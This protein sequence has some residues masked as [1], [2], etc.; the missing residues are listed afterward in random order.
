[1]KIKFFSS[2]FLAVLFIA[3]CKK[4]E[5]INDKE[6][7]PSKKIIS[8]TKSAGDGVYDLLGFGYD[9]TKEF[10]NSSSATFEVIDINRFVADY[11][12]RITPDLSKTSYGQLASGGNI[13]SYSRS[14]SANITSTAT[15]KVFTGTITGAYSNTATSSSK[16]LYG[17]YSHIAQ[18]KR[19][20]LNSPSNILKDYLNQ[21]FILDLENSSAQYVVQKYGTHV[22]LDI[23]LGGKLEIL[24]QSETS[25]SNR[26]IA[27]SAGINL[28]VDKLFNISRNVSYNSTDASENFSQNLNYKTHGGDPTTNLFGQITLGENTLPKIDIT[29]W[30]NSLTLENAELV[31]IGQD[32][33]I[34]IYELIDDFDKRIELE[35]YVNQYMIAK[36]AKLLDNFPT[37][38]LYRCYNTSSG[39]HILTTNPGE[40]SGQRYWIV[41]GEFGNI[42]T[43]N[44][45][46]NTTPLYRYYYNKYHFFTTN[47]N[48]LGT[49]NG[50]Q[51]IVGY[52]NSINEAG[53]KTIYRYNSRRGHVYCNNFD[54]L[55]WGNSTWSYEGITGYIR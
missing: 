25:K 46:P 36:G 4:Q 14:L 15:F 28:G 11:P 55:G 10:G 39:D 16:Y 17:S 48:E 5:I 6:T 50:Y 41:E 47:L 3:S 8:E 32:G 40:V 12:S 53:F 1:M 20:K 35:N 43:D 23:K 24:Y 49:G 21:D 22:L 27:A 30:L 52:V 51:G 29:E 44:S 45:K 13:E 18:Q 37:Q 31:D 19:W 54:E 7:F 34:P 33:L 2:I 9:V 38:K 42:Y 26:D